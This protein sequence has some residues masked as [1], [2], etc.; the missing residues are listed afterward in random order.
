MLYAFEASAREASLVRPGRE[1][2]EECRRRREGR[3]EAF[4]KQ[5]VA[6]GML[7]AARAAS[8]RVFHFCRVG[9]LVAREEAMSRLLRE[10]ASWL[11]VSFDSAR[12]L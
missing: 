8:P 11:G 4:S 7:K 5:V 9:D 6:R 1:E 12:R 10:R 3:S 2:V